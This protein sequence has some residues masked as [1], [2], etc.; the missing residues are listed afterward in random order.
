V[1]LRIHV[2]LLSLILMVFTANAA[3]AEIWVC[4]QPDGSELFTDQPKKAG[5]C[6]R[7][8]PTTQL[9]YAPP[10]NWANM[11]P[12]DPMA[13]ARKAQKALRD[14]QAQD[15]AVTD[16]SQAYDAPYDG[17]WEDEEPQVY[18]QFYYGVPFFRHRHNPGFPHKPTRHAQH[19]T[20]SAS[21]SLKPQPS[22]QPQEGSPRFGSE[23]PQRSA[24]YIVP[25]IGHPQPPAAPSIGTR[26]GSGGTAPASRESA[27]YIVPPIGQEGRR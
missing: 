15:T 12:R 27:P 11:P 5:S 3:T 6:L 16:D 18:T 14:S 23:V 2:L 20:S 26:E 24:P 17:F 7:H 8:D 10:T 13:E 22:E 4:S 9:V 1:C 21:T 25:P 19:N